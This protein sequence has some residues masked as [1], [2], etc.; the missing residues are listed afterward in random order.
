MTDDRFRA[1]V[2]R[3]LLLLLLLF[4]GVVWAGLARAHEWYP[5]ECC[6]DKD[7]KAMPL[8]QT[9]TATQSGWL[10]Y[11]GKIWPYTSTRTAPDGK[12]HECVT[13]AG[14]RLCLFAPN[15]GS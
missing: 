13:P 6:S 11:D 10:L 9:P 5:R 8:D 12:F 4:W 14:T 1:Q 2:W 3:W 7:C 15:S